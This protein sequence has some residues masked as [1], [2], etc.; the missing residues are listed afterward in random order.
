MEDSDL[1][2]EALKK[3]ISKSIDKTAEKWQVDMAFYDLQVKYRRLSTGFQ[4]LAENTMINFEE[5]YCGYCGRITN[6]YHREG[7]MHLC[8]EC[9]GKLRK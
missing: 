4:I 8:A 5:N 6:Y 1:F 7:E 3:N 9:H 2:L